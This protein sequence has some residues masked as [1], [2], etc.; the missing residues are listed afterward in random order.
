MPTRWPQMRANGDGAA[1]PFGARRIRPHPVHS[2]VG[3]KIMSIIFGCLALT[4]SPAAAETQSQ[5]KIEAAS[6]DT[7]RWAQSKPDNTL[8]TGFTAAPKRS[9]DVD[10]DNV[11]EKLKQC[12]AKWNRKLA[13]YQKSLPKMKKYRTYY[14]RWEAYPA[15]RPPQWPEPML[16]RESYRACIYE[17]LGDS[18]SVCPGGWP[19]DDK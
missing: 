5:S 2:E 1:A 13:A 12:G 19:A 15:Q 6:R 4:V 14:D 7:S 3:M 17:C 18:N 9:P 16:T 10:D 11:L 8:T